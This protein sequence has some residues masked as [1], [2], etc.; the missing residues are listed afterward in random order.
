[1]SKLKSLFKELVGLVDK[2]ETEI[3]ILEPTNPVEPSIP[4]I[5]RNI[6]ARFEHYTGT[7]VNIAATEDNSFVDKNGNQVDFT[8]RIPLLLREDDGSIILS[9]SERNIGNE[10]MLRQYKGNLMF[11][12]S[13]NSNVKD[14]I[15]YVV[16]LS[17]L[18]KEELFHFAIPVKVGEAPI[19]VVNG[20]RK[21][22]GTVGSRFFTTME[23]TDAPIRLGSN[24]WNDGKSSA[25][26]GE[27]LIEKGRAWSVEEV[28]EDYIKM[29]NIKDFYLTKSED[30][31]Y[32]IPVEPNTGEDKSN[33]L[34]D[35]F[36]RVP[37]GNVNPSKVE[38]K[39]G[40][41]LVNMEG[42]DFSKRVQ[43]IHIFDKH[44]IDVDFKGAT[45][46]TTKPSLSKLDG[47]IDS[48]R[49]QLST[50]HSSGI[51]VQN[52]DIRGSLNQG[53]Y[54]EALELEHAIANTYSKKLYYKNINIQNVW[55]DGIY[56]KYC[57]DAT[58]ENIL[59]SGTNRMA[60]GVSHGVKNLKII[61]FEAYNCIRASLDL[62]G[63][64][65]DGLIDGVE[66][67]NSFLT[68]Y[69]AAAGNSRI[70]N[71]NL[72]HNRYIR[73]IIMKGN[74]WIDNPNY[75]PNI[76][77]SLSNPKEINAEPRENWFV[78]DN[79]LIGGGGTPMAMVRIR[80]CKNVKVN[81]NNI[82]VPTTQGRWGIDLNYCSGRIE[83]IGNKYENPCIHRI[84]NCAAGT[85]V[86][87]DEP[88]NDNVYIIEI[89]GVKEV[90]GTNPELLALIEKK[91]Y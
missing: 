43:A 20:L 7:P 56:L 52:L 6:I 39:F 80:Y 89:D 3:E 37:S 67:T 87:I 26:T 46:E 12:M 86:I 15:R 11:E 63:D 69:L 33:E 30:G 81:R 40:K 2:I 17:E 19:F 50:D 82:L 91:G 23:K 75:N 4:V 45:L 71:V 13:N 58:L 27:V 79:E 74:M 28:V 49:F 10:W 65:V 60:I 70:N 34:S 73:T 61:N 29:F 77:E 22:V 78:E 54:E 84:L 76:P 38:M 14:A 8:I 85:E 66:M 57:E 1:M 31:I 44:D 53:N 32:H 47:D 72:H 21:E 35:S 90:R 24:G 83:I 64:S 48:K 9:K 55:G 5:E 41:Y 62:E 68:N 36:N 42:V 88:N 25:H 18:P 51:S 59:T 16:P